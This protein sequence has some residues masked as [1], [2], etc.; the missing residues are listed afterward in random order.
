V[1]VFDREAIREVDRLAVE[2]Y[3]LPSIIMMEN[4]ARGVAGVIVQGL[5]GMSG[6]AVV[7]FAGPGNN[8]GDGLAVARH[9]ANQGMRVGVVLAA[10]AGRYSGD[11]AVNLEVCRRMG[12]AMVQAHGD[13]GRAVEQMVG[14]MGAP[15]VVVDGLLGTGATRAARGP[16]GELIGRINDLR[17]GG[18][19]VV[20]IDLPSGLDAQTGGPCP[21][22]NGEPG[23]CVEADITVTLAGLKR[24]FVDEA[25]QKYVGQ[26]VVVDIGVPAALL[27]R[28]G[29]TLGELRERAAT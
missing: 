14:L 11:A 16:I 24:G 26:M 1:L 15:E 28:L 23:P 3:G 21:A 5:E 22:D 10:E 19:T 18:S 27:R 8:G 9:L 6:A 25:C 13:P 12:L 17:R 7:V 2:E 29:T 4:A 20:A